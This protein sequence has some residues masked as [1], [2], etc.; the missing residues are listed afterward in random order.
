MV[1]TSL[2]V[3]ARL[4]RAQAVRQ[5]R[6]AIEG[7]A[8]QDAWTLHVAEQSMLKVADPEYRRVLQLAVHVHEPQRRPVLRGEQ[9]HF[10][11]WRFHRQQR[12]RF[13]PLAGLLC[14]SGG[15]GVYIE[16]LEAA[17]PKAAPVA[18][19]APHMDQRIKEIVSE[20]NTNSQDVAFE[21]WMSGQPWNQWP[22]RP[23]ETDLRE[24][25]REA[26]AGSRLAG[27]ELPAP[28]RESPGMAA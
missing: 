10:R 3:N 11:G 23:D 7:A 27:R 2:S 18:A 6:E 26:M 19:P 15:D 8:T 16:R 24:R 17:R 22:G 13:R 4:M 21:T 9:A 5:K 1:R 12:V 14:R 25:L 20:N 28:A